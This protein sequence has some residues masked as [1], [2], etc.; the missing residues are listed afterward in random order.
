MTT[1]TTRPLEGTPGYVAE[2]SRLDL[3]DI[4]GT[5]NRGEKMWISQPT[6][7]Q[8]QP[9]FSP[10]SGNQIGSESPICIAGKEAGGISSW[11]RDRDG[12]GVLAMLKMEPANQAM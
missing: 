8:R 7:K 4:V 10:S 5:P 6:S 3:G 12:F 1:E 9:K 2:D 11:Q